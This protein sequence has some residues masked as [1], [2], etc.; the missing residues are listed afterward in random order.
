MILS[1]RIL[2]YC[3]L[4]LKLWNVVLST[5]GGAPGRV[6]YYHDDKSAKC[7]YSNI[8]FVLLVWSNRRG[9]ID[10]DWQMRERTY[11]GGIDPAVQLPRTYMTLW[12]LFLIRSF[13][14]SYEQ[15]WSHWGIENMSWGFVQLPKRVAPPNHSTIPECRS[16]KLACQSS[17]GEEA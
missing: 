12:R 8:S 14:R 3:K 11:L 1:K 13:R 9:E 15:Q 4:A 10:Q 16:L 7:R 2:K 5:G 6:K 17:S